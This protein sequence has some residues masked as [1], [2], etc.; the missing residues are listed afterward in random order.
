MKLCTIIGMGPGMGLAIARRFGKGGYNIAMLAR[1]AETLESAGLALEQEGIKA[2]GYL[3]DAGDPAK[4][5]TVLDAVHAQHG[6]T[7]VLV[8]NAAILKPGPLASLTT[9]RLREEFRVNVA[10]AVT[11]VQAVLKPMKSEGGGCIIFTGGGFGLE[12]NPQWLSLSIGKAGLRNLAF[13]LH[14]ELGS[15]NIHVGVVTI[16]GYVGSNAHFAADNIAEAYWQ[17]NADPRGGYR[18]EIQYR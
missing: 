5:T 6:N 13:S 4:L 17:L 16:C 9:E 11:A 8:Y 3:A 1:K 18:P 12:P 2:H 14:E 15:Q 7:N 10:G